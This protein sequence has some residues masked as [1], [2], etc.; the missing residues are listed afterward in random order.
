MLM[1]WSIFYAPETWIYVRG[2]LCLMVVLLICL[3]LKT[4]QRQTNKEKAETLKILEA[5]EKQLTDVRDRMNKLEA[6]AGKKMKELN[7]AGG[8]KSVIP[9]HRKDKRK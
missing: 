7:E 4:R 2:F 1:L 5:F 8:P 3:Q 9:M 6:S